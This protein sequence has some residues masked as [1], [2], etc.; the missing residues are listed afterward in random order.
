MAANL[1]DEMESLPLAKHCHQVDACR[2][3]FNRLA[4][5]PSYNNLFSGAFD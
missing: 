5:G 1:L 4:L 2:G 3:A